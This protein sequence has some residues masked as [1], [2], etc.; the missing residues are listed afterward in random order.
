MNNIL[1]KSLFLILV[2]MVSCNNKNASTDAVA[3]PKPSVSIVHPTIGAIQKREQI[4]GQIVYLNKTTVTAP[5]TGY[6]TTVNTA[7]GNWVKKGDLLFKIQTKES[8]ALKDSNLSP[9]NQFGIISVFASAMGYVNTLNITD[10]GVYIT[11]GSAMA[12]IVKNEDIAVQ[13]NAPY[14]YSKLLNSSNTIDIEL[15]N[16]EVLPATFYKAIPMV[17][18]VSQTQQMLFKLKKYSPLPENLNVIVSLLSSEKA[19]SVML[20]K[21][22]ILTNETQDEFWIMKVNQDSLSIKVPIQKG[23]ENAN[24]VEILSPKLTPADAIIQQGA[25][26]LPDSTKVKIN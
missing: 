26:G 8:K 7:L 25:Y 13:V 5:I 6:V 19:N 15:P 10:S 16:K 20:P 3:L 24:T 2:F 21:D 9:S 14:N 22:A 11:E 4:N 18:P 17:D 12:T 23:I 1:P